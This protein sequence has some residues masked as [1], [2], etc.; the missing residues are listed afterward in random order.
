MADVT[1][2]D[3]IAFISSLLALCWQSA[4]ATWLY[5][6]HDMLFFMV[7]AGG[8]SQGLVKMNVLTKNKTLKI[9]IRWAVFKLQVWNE[10]SQ[11]KQVLFLKGKSQ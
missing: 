2:G 3:V 8:V 1:G 10:F 6:L 9:K 11:A 5:I 7:N 4:A